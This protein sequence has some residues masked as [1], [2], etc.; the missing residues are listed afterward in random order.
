MKNLIKAEWFKLTKSQ[1]FRVLLVINLTASVLLILLLSQAGM[2]RTGY[3]AFHLGIAYLFYIY[4][5]ALF[6]QPYFGVK[7]FPIN[8]LEKVC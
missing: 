5:L 1:V 4:I 6:L 8:H 2:E 3:R 7:I